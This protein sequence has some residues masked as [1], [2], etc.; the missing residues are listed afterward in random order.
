MFAVE[1]FKEFLEWNPRDSFVAKADEEQVIYSYL[2]FSETMKM[3]DKLLQL[4]K[5][6]W[7]VVL[8]NS[9]RITMFQ[10]SHRI[11]EWI[12]EIRWDWKSWNGNQTKAKWAV[13]ML[14]SF[15][16][17]LPFFTDGLEL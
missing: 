3:I 14:W 9:I 8:S 13:E 16:Y 15:P 6:N 2:N 17:N 1:C 12:P 11:T 4:Q 7:S 5:I 10:D